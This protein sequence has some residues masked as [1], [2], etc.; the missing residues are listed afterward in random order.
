MEKSYMEA[1]KELLSD[2]FKNIKCAFILKIN[3]ADII[4]AV[5]YDY[6]TRQDSYETRL[7]YEGYEIEA[8]VSNT[9]KINNGNE[10]RPEFLAAIINGDQISGDDVYAKEVKEKAKKIA[11]GMT[12][13]QLAIK[14]TDRKDENFWSGKNSPTPEEAN[15]LANVED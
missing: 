11:A 3:E 10:K 4:L 8:C 6:V 15:D 2:R 12:K 1:V 7:F 14:K 13:E 9:E 5:I